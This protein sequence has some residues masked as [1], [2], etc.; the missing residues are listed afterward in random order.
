MIWL[1][2]FS[3]GIDTLLSPDSLAATP[4]RMSAK[5]AISFL[6]VGIVLSNIRARKGS[7]AH[8][9]DTPE[10]DSNEILTQVFCYSFT[11]RKQTWRCSFIHLP[12]EIQSCGQSA[13]RPPA[14]S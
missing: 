13:N 10:N 4:G 5:T 14:A 1:W 11:C 3:A 9:I 6:L 8:M 2:H 7:V 12:V